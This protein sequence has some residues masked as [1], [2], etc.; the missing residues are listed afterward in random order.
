MLRSMRI[1]G[2]DPGLTRA[3]IGILE[4]STVSTM[5]ALEWMVIT[6]E[7]KLPQPER[8]QELA[9]DLDQIISDYSPDLAVVETLFFATN[10]KTAMATAEA[11]GVILQRLSSRG[12]PIVEATPLQLKMSITGDGKADKKQIQSMVRRILKLETIPEPFD[13]ADAL[14][15]ALFGSYTTGSPISPIVTRR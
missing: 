4:G 15:L 6:T 13:A 14:A 8:L 3:G 10:T 2:I 1:L 11:R 12:I 7:P 9:T 5:K